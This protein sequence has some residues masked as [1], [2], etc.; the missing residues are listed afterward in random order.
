MKPNKIT[1]IN[2]QQQGFTLIE[3]VLAIAISSIIGAAVATAMYQTERINSSSSNRQS[4]IV[5]VQNA[6]QSIS[7]DAQQAQ[8]VIP[9]DNSGE[10]K[11]LDTYPLLTKLIS[12]DLSAGDKIMFQ[13][14]TW[15]S[16]LYQVTYSLVNGVLKKTVVIDGVVGVQTGAVVANNIINNTGGDFSGSWD[17]KNKVLNVT[18]LEATVG[19][20]AS[21]ISETRSFQIN[22]RAAQ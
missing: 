12:F 2:R 19:N 4:A 9:Q 11:P 21:Q 20:G 16:H 22:P 15:D 18:T 10:A 14:Y 8:Q 3:L 5:Q 7:R 17:T 6:V 13:W 1:A